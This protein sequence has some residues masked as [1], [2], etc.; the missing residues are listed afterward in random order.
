[1]EMKRK[2]YFT[3]FTAGY[4]VAVI[5]EFNSVIDMILTDDFVLP[6]QKFHTST[7]CWGNVS[8]TPTQQISDVS[9]L[10]I[11]ATAKS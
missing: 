1:M 2:W 4:Y 6:R 8:R 3:C 10:F 5:H 11:A 9:T 7:V